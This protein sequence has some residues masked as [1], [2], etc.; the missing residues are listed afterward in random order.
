LIFYAYFAA[1]PQRADRFLERCTNAVASPFGVTGTLSAL[2]PN[3]CVRLLVVAVMLVTNGRTPM[4]FYGPS[5]RFP[6]FV[7]DRFASKMTLP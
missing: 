1:T 2:E 4:I 3:Y 7:Y 6:Q 5:A